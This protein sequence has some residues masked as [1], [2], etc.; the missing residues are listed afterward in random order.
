MG[1]WHHGWG[2]GGWESL[3]VGGLMMLVFFGA[4]FALLVL[5]VR[6]GLKDGDGSS[7]EGRSVDRALQILA[8]RY[9]QGEIDSETYQQMRRELEA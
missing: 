8:E 6:L 4:T 3:I 9:A 7:Q 5:A 1:W 2:M